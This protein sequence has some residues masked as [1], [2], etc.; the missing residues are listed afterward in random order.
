[1][2]FIHRPDSTTIVIEDL[3]HLC[4]DDNEFKNSMLNSDKVIEYNRI[5]DPNS[6]EPI[7]FYLVFNKNGTILKY[8]AK[9]LSLGLDEQV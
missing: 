3:F 1:M 2:K 4:K 7:I 6:F 5:I 8:A 9:A